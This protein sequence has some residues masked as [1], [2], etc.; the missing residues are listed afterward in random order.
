MIRTE[1]C[2]PSIA[3][4]SFPAR[5][6]HPRDQ[7]HRNRTSRHKVTAVQSYEILEKIKRKKHEFGLLGLYIFDD[8]H[9]FDK[10][11]RNP[12]DYGFEEFE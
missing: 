7:E 6:T 11:H 3:F 5:A 4:S 2:I 10:N 1:N 8:F 9:G 12:S